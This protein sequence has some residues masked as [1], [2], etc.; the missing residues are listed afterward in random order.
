MRMLINLNQ[1][2]RM[3]L[4]QNQILFILEIIMS[5]CFSCG[6]RVHISKFCSHKGEGFK[7]FNV[8]IFATR[9]QNVD[10][11]VENMKQIF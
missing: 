7:I 8:V 3:S 6:G 1:I 9:F 4:G 10:K 11:Q 5:V 2:I